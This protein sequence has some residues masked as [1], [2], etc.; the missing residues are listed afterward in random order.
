MYAPFYLKCF[1]LK[2]IVGIFF[3][4]VEIFKTL[5]FLKIVFIYGCAGS[6]LLF[7]SCG[8]ERGPSLVAVHG[9]LIMVAS[10]VAEHGLQGAWASVVVAQGLSRAA[11]MLCSMWGPPRSRI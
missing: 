10:L 8:T 2:G 1:Q 3:R 9:L 5:I 4:S 6:L 11:Q 7:S